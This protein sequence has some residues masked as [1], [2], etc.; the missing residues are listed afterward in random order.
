VVRP[1]THAPVA[2]TPVAKSD[3][4][5][6]GF[7]RR[8]LAYVIDSVFLF[9]VQLILATGVLLVAPGD[10]RSMLNVA[11]VSA[12]IGWAYFALFE[13]SPARGTLGK[14]ALSLYVGDLHGDPI[15][16]R[17]AVLRNALKIISWLL[18]GFGFVFAAFSPRKQ[19]LHDLLAGT[20]VL[21]EVRYFVIGPEAPT[22]PGDHWDGGR[23]VASVP[24]LEKS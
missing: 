17:R 8:L 21:R 5:Y 11:P 2:Y 9:G 20:L 7:W 13:S 4:A 3:I 24:P 15:T 16:F 23:W 14:K 12:A 18:L 22:E 10:L 6:A 19:A 1:M